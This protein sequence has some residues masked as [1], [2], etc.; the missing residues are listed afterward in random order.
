MWPALL[1]LN[2]LGIYAALIGCLGA[3]FSALVLFNKHAAMQRKVGLYGLRSVAWGLFFVG[4]SLFL[5]VGQTLQSGF[6]GM[7]DSG[8]LFFLWNTPVGEVVRVRTTGLL[9]AGL[10]FGLIIYRISRTEKLWSLLLCGS[11][12]L[13]AA[14]TFVSGHTNSLTWLPKVA[15]ALHLMTVGF[16]IGSLMPL[17]WAV[18]ELQNRDLAILLKRFGDMAIWLV[19]ILV[20]C[21]GYLIIELLGSPL[22]LFRST[23]GGG[24]ILKISLV[25][26]LLLLAA[27][28]R[29]ALVPRIEDEQTG[30]QAESK[31][32]FH[33]TLVFEMIFAAAILFTTAAITTITGPEL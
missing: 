19:V 6:M 28:N 12:F 29:Y 25:A 23:Y 33:V 9:I 32:E 10:G 24:L 16:W 27:R 26:G 13:L 14:S 11:V 1:V 15:I 17:Y 2:K 3:S 4:M 8:L 5:Q 18:S 30:A 20:I 31:D 21:G 7:F 22:N